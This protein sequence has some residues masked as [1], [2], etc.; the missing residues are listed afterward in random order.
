V[1]SGVKNLVFWAVI[2]LSAFLLWQVVRTNPTEQ[3]TPEISYSDFLS[4]VEA[5][6]VAKVTVA[7]NEVY[8][9]YRDNGSFRV[10]VPASQEGMIQALHQK[11]VE[12]WFRDVAGGDWATWLMNLAPLVLLAALWFFMIRQLR[13]A[14]L[15]AQRE[16]V[17][18]NLDAHLK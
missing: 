6:N 4:Q 10:I 12:I 3:K 11:G 1:N 13:S 8:G 14:K 16:R 15:P 17:P 2:I 9:R 18:Q 7:R 5:G